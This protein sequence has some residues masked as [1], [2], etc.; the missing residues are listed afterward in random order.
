MNWNARFLSTVAAKRQCCRGKY[1][2]LLDVLHHVLSHKQ[3]WR[4]RY[5]LV[6][7]LKRQLQ[8]ISNHCPIASIKIFSI[9]SA[10]HIFARTHLVDVQL[11]PS[12]ATRGRACDLFKRDCGPWWQ[13]HKGLVSVC[14]KLSLVMSR[15]FC[16]RKFSDKYFHRKKNASDSEVSECVLLAAQI[17]VEVVVGDR[18]DDQMCKMFFLVI[19]YF[20]C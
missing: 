15:D 11:E 4:W 5:S 8:K 7:L 1:L 2:Y 17:A 13:S 6:P 9:M 3:S 16:K 20:N 19:C 14:W 10:H 18:R 12:V